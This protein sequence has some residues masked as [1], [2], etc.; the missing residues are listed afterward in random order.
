MGSP[1]RPLPLRL[2]YTRHGLIPRVFAAFLAVIAVVSPRIASGTSLVDELPPRFFGGPAPTRGACQEL[3]V[4]GPPRR[5]GTV[6]PGGR[7]EPSEGA[8]R[9]CLQLLSQALATAQPDE[10]GA[11]PTIVGRERQLLQTW[12]AIKRMAPWVK[13]HAARTGTPGLI[14][15]LGTLE[16]RAQVVLRAQGLAG[17]SYGA[18]VTGG[19]VTAEPGGQV[20]SVPGA[21]THGVTAGYVALAAETRPLDL[22][23]GW[24][25]GFGLRLARQPVLAMVTS[26]S[27]AEPLFKNGTSVATELRFAQTSRVL[28]LAAV[29][30][31]GATR[32]DLAPTAV[33]SGGT[34]RVYSAA[35]NDIDEWALFFD[36]R[37]D[38]RWYDRDVWADRLTME[39]LDPLLRASVGIRHDERFHRAGDLQPFNDPTGRVFFSFT[40]HPVRT[41]A[42][43]AGGGFEFEGALRGAHRLPSGYQLF[44]EATLDLRRALRRRSSR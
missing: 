34:T 6:I 9:A 12:Q 38:V 26:N 11:A 14:D 28:E 17:G 31:A 18:V 30:R 37:V 42:I 27:G 24:H 8:L 36:A 43:S 10:A 16:Q 21:A 7:A 33:R 3:V 23:L 5:H 22:G 15:D 25:A 44:A 20:N 19:V 4:Q 35:A 32:I 39:T 2:A 13:R 29:S 41:R 1:L 40:L